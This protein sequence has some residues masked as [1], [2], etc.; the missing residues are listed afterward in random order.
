MSPQTPGV[1]L[2]VRLRRDASGR[3]ASRHVP[4]PAFAGSARCAGRK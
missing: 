1:V 4:R 2:E 3:L